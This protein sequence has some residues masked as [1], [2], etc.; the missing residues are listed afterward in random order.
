VVRW[1]S[2][3]TSNSDTLVQGVAGTASE[4]DG[5][6][7]LSSGLPGK[8]DRCASLSVQA[9]GRNVE[10]VGAIGFTTLSKSKKGRG[11][12]GQEGGC[13]ETH[14]DVEVVVSEVERLWVAKMR[15]DGLERIEIET[16]G[17]LEIE[18]EKKYRNE[19]PKEEQT[20]NSGER[21]VL[22]RTVRD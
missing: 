10:G 11:G 20:S 21:V 2:K 1:I 22:K 6:L 15:C 13:G 18:R 17:R 7:A 5:D 16:L 19:R 9:L 4:V 8:V 3:R 14:L 12:D